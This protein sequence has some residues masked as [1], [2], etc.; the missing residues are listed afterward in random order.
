MS[1]K[2]K[3]NLAYWGDIFIQKTFI[4]FLIV[5]LHRTA[6]PV[7]MPHAII[8][9]RVQYP[10]LR[11]YIKFRRIFHALKKDEHVFRM[12][13]FCK[14]NQISVRKLECMFNKYIC[15][16][17]SICFILDRFHNTMNQLLMKNYD[18][19]SDLALENTPFQEVNTEG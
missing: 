18:K 10:L 4:Y 8:K 3:N 17:A 11:D 19:Y 5:L 12:S 13:A 1:S 9:Y 7:Q 14:T 2:N 16:S 15:M 6:D